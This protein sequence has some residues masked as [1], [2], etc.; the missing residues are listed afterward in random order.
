MITNRKF[1]ISPVEE[2]KSF[3]VHVEIEEEI[4]AEDVVKR[5]DAINKDLDAIGKDIEKMPQIVEARSR[6]LESD[7]K[8]ME[9]ENSCY[10]GIE[11]RARL[12]KKENELKNERAGKTE[13]PAQN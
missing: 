13:E 12:W 7:K 6:Q 5:M 8:M 3:L 10:A 2:R 1:A 11:A 4:S 9:E